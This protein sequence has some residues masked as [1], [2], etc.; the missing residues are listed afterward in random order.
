MRKNE[1]HAPQN[2]KLS[3]HRVILLCT[4]LLL[5][6]CA[7][8]VGFEWV[9]HAKYSSPDY[10]IEYVAQN[11]PELIALAEELLL[12]DDPVKAPES[13]VNSPILDKGKITWVQTQGGS[14][15]FLIDFHYAPMEGRIGLIYSPDGEYDFTLNPSDWHTVPGS[16]ADTLRWEG[17]MGGRGWVEVTRLSDC[18]FFEKAAIPT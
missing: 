4:A 8:S 13:I 9:D 11:E 10:Y 12:P 1:I 18:F 3:T 14:V 17:G 15:V 7:A 5:L 16:T 2:E 6:F